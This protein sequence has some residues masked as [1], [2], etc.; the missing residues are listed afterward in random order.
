MLP[1]LL[2]LLPIGRFSESLLVLL[3]L[4]L[5]L[6]LL[7]C[8]KD[9]L[10]NAT[11]TTSTTTYWP[12][13]RKLESELEVWKTDFIQEIKGD[14]TEKLQSQEAAIKLIS[15]FINTMK[16]EHLNSVNR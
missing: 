9:F 2:V 15:R 11:T 4:L 12:F 6:P 8:F 10:T 14:L 13:Q 3:L 5:L 7:L 1:L 16:E